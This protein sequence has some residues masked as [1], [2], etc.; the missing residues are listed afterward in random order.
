MIGRSRKIFFFT[1]GIKK[2]LS[3]SSVKPS[4]FPPEKLRAY[5]SHD[6]ADQT[7]ECLLQYELT[8]SNF[9]GSVV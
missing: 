3:K 1:F 7:D 6:T 5:T 9:H 2:R 8:H 4:E